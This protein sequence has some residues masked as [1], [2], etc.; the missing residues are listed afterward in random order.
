MKRATVSRG[1]PTSTP[2]TTSPREAY[3]RCSLS[4]TGISARHGRHQLAQKSR[5]TGRPFRLLRLTKFPDRSCKLKSGATTAFAFALLPPFAPL[6]APLGRVARGASQKLCRIAGKRRRLDAIDLLAIDESKPFAG[7]CFADFA[8]VV[9]V[10]LDFES[11]Y[12]RGAF[13]ERLH[14][15]AGMRHLGVNDQ[16]VAL[17]RGVAGKLDIYSGGVAR[18]GVGANSKPARKCIS[19]QVGERKKPL[20]REMK[21]S[22]S[23]SSWP[24]CYSRD[25]VAARINSISSGGSRW[26]SRLPIFLHFAKLRRNSI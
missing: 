3:S 2:I 11:V 22:A 20:R 19:A 25:S 15:I 21:G 16:R 14:G 10:N 24:R 9:V 23:G 5:S 4:T 18:L 13:L 17:H 12:Y 26:R 6:C 8:P 1:S 7:A